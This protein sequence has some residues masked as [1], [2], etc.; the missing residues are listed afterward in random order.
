MVVQSSSTKQVEVEM[1]HNLTAVSTTVHRE[2]VAA[3][4]NPLFLSYI[5]SP[6]DKT[7]DE[8][9]L[10]TGEVCQRS[11]VRLGHN[12]HMLRCLRMYVPES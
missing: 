5:I 12:E 6:Q 11:N 8:C 9:L 3:F 4:G 7:T 10:L 2:A 1:R